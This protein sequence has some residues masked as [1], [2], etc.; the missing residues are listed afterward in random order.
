[1]SIR[2][3]EVVTP[4]RSWSFENIEAQGSACELNRSYILVN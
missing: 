4:V 3:A 2:F 1:M